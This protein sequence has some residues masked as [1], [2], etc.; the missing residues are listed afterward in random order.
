MN[1]VFNCIFSL[2]SHVYDKITERCDDALLHCAMNGFS[3]INCF[4]FSR[5]LSSVLP[6]DPNSNLNLNF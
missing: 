3:Q 4:H 1:T 2:L 5:E 6:A